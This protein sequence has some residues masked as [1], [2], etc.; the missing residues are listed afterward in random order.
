MAHGTSRVN[1]CHNCRQ[2]TLVERFSSDPKCP[3]CG[4]TS[5]QTSKDD[6][7]KKYTITLFYAWVLHFNH[8]EKIK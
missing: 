7:R 2:Y 8:W 5:S 6:I 1:I 4:K 3:T